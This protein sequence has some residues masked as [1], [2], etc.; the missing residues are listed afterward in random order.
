[1]QAAVYPTLPQVNIFLTNRR[2]YALML[3]HSASTAGLR[4]GL[5]PVSFTILQC[6]CRSVPLPEV[7]PAVSLDPCYRLL[8]QPF[9]CSTPTDCCAQTRCQYSMLPLRPFPPEA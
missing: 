9:R 7:L 4:Q 3:Q 8:V 2:G 6:A 1:M 5:S